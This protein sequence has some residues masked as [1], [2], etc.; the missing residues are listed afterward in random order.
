MTLVPGFVIQ[1][2]AEEVPTDVF[3][4]FQLAVAGL[5]DFCEMSCVAGST[6]DR[7]HLAVS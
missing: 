2:C 6:Q 7:C 5:H 1:P 4:Q 3:L